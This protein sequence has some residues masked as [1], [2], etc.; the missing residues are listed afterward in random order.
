LR[1]KTLYLEPD[2]PL[3][4]ELIADIAAP[5]RDFLSYH[6]AGNLIVE[7]SDPPDFSKRLLAAL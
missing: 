3:E 5:M 4:D 7:Q 1:I 2:I 6:Q